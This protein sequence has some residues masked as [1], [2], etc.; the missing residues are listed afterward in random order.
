MNLRMNNQ[1]MYLLVLRGYMKKRTISILEMGYPDNKWQP[2]SMDEKTMLN[3]AY[4]MR[5][6]INAIQSDNYL[7]IFRTKPYIDS[8]YITYD[9]DREAITIKRFTFHE[10]YIWSREEEQFFHRACVKTLM[11]KEMK[12]VSG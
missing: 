1:G 9:E 11:Y 4:D 7:H 5:N 10:G 3:M 2:P 12:Y 6:D 8:L